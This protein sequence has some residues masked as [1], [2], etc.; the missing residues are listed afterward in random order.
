MKSRDQK[1]QRNHTRRRWRTGGLIL[2]TALFVPACYDGVQPPPL[3]PAPTPST[4]PARLVLTA[5]SGF[6]QQLTVSAQVLSSSGLAVPNVTVAFAIG[7]GTIT[8]S[9][10]TT[11]GTGTAGATAISTA[12]TTISAVTSGGIGSSVTVLSSQSH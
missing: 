11:D 8:P 2:A 6:N 12:N 1:G 5:S 7:A 9:T 4:S 10:T 3:P